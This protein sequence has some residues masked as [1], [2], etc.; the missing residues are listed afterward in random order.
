MFA[1]VPPIL[2]GIPTHVHQ[3]GKRLVEKGH[4]VHVVSFLNEDG[5]RNLN[6]IEVHGLKS[7]YDL[8]DMYSIKTPLSLPKIEEK[9]NEIN[10]DILHMHHRT[11]LLE[12]FPGKIKEMTSAPLINTVHC[13][14]G[15]TYPPNLRSTIYRLHYKAISKILEENSDRVISVSDYN[16]K[17]LIDGGVSPKK[18]EVIRNG[19]D[20][21][22]YNQ[23]SKEDARD[24]LNIDSNKLVVM[25]AGRL[26]VEK[27][28]PYLI[29]G[30]KEVENEPM[31]LRIA[32]EGLLDSV[33]KLMGK[34]DDRIN[35][36]GKLEEDKIIKNYKAADIFVLPSA[37]PEAQAIVLFE[38]MAAKLP[39]IATDTGGT[40]EL[41]EKT[42]SGVLV[43]PRSEKVLKETIEKLS[44]D[45]KKRERLGNQGYESVKKEFNWG[46]ITDKTLEVYKSTLQD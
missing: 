6:G 41:I 10:P 19:V 25:Y 32:G 20:V 12:F 17:E 22:K 35:F 44:N 23:I 38:A 27:G 37:I 34:K 1:S 13:S 43:E 45:R 30:F 5:D 40:T 8:A 14:P 29:S 42:N 39:I 18:I 3:I 24:E 31:E 7:Y 36:L 2:S 28:L 9:L 15:Y 16:K 26:S 33:Y 4:E 46:E 11:S 21:N